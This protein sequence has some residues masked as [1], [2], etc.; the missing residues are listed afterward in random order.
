LA[1]SWGQNLYHEENEIHNFGRGLPA[2]HHYVLSLSSTCAVVEKIF[3]NLSILNSFVPPSRP[4]WGHEI[5]NFWSPS[6]IVA[7]SQ[8]FLKLVQWLQ[9]RSKQCSKVYGRRMTD[10]A[11]KQKAIDH[12]SDSGDP[13]NHMSYEKRPTLVGIGPDSDSGEKG[14]KYKCLTERRTGRRTVTQTTHNW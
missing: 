7:I 14:Q 3:E 2:L 8:I 13:Q 5:N 11:R 6:P 4:Q 1:P 9:R 10:G 12:L